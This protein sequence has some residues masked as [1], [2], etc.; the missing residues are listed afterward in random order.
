MLRQALL[1]IARVVARIGANPADS[2]EVRLSKAIGVS[3]TV[4]GALPAILIWTVLFF[5]FDEAD[6]AWIGA[7]WAGLIIIGLVSFALTRRGFSFYR[8]LMLLLLLVM[9]F[10]IPIRLGG[11]INS[12]A[13]ILW[14]LMAPLTA[15]VLSGP[16]VALRWFLGFAVLVIASGMLETQVRAPNHLPSV[17]ITVFFVINILGMAGIILVILYYFVLQRDQAFGLLKVEQQKSE[18]LLLNILPKEIAHILKNENRTI[19]DQFDS[20]SILF[21]DIV[22]FT[23]MSA[24]MTPTALVDLLNEVFSR[25]DVLVEKYGLEKIKTIGDCYMVAAGVPRPRSDHAH[26]LTRLALDIRD[27]VSQ[28]EFR[29]QKL[30]FRIGLNSGPV[31]A[32]VIGRQKFIYDLW[33]DAVNTASRMEAYGAGGSIQITE[34]TYELIKDDFLCEPRGVVKVKGKGEMN[35]WYVLEEKI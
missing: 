3:A 12:S 16:Q 23:P 24:K 15:L 34:T 5:I 25:F 17:M 21:A 11:M 33:G 28:H 29:N 27:Y 7:G 10:I 8:F 9:S 14:G 20:A 22:N 18:S 6:A 32:G 19:A 1:D 2:E 26:I 31:V 13:F 30:A 4:F 35:V